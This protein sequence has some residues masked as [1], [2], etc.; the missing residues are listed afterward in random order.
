[1]TATNVSADT[2]KRQNTKVKGSMVSSPIFIIGNDVPHKAP[3]SSVK[4]IALALL[5][6]NS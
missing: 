3:A 1:M 6:S 5:L 2:R 4:N